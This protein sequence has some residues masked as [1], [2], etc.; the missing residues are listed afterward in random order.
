[1]FAIKMF[2]GRGNGELDPGSNRELGTFYPDQAWIFR[3]GETPTC[4]YVIQRGQVE[5]VLETTRSADGQLENWDERLAVLGEGEIFGEVAMFTGR[6]H[7]TSARAVGDARV[8]K[9]DRRT[10]VT[11]LHVDPSLAF[12]II[13]RLS[14]RVYELDSG[15]LQSLKL[16]GERDELTGFAHYQDVNVLLEEEVSR[17]KRLLYTMAFAVIDINDFNLIHTKY[18][19]NA[20]DVL[21]LGL[22]ET[23][24]KHLRRTD[25]VGRY[26]RDRFGVILFEANGQAAVAILEKIR[27]AFARQIHHCQGG[28][29]RASFGCGI[30][31]LPEHADAAMLRRAANRALKQCRSLPGKSGVV[32][33]GEEILVALEA[34]HGKP[35]PK[36]I[37][38]SWFDWR[39]LIQLSRTRWWDDEEET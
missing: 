19:K 39:N 14:E 10:F 7:F 24:R 26:G 21:L 2:N 17:A 25:I 12:R 23:L 33:A 35:E 16:H 20:G 4:L 18:G 15:L 37:S 32:L 6:T 3:H 36:S 9:V 13:E 27:E 38:D 11:K 5:L 29:F 28:S 8:M 34:K 31:M 30:A 22:A 1:M